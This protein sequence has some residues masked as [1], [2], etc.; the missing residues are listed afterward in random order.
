MTSSYARRIC[1]AAG[2]ASYAQTAARV[3]LVVAGRRNSLCAA[4]LRAAA[5]AASARAAAACSIRRVAPQ[6]Y[7]QQPYVPQAYP[8]QTY[9]PAYAQQPPSS[10]NGAAAIAAA[11]PP[12]GGPYVAAP[13]GYASAPAN[14]PQAYYAR[15]RRQAARRGVRP[16]RH[17]QQLHWSMPAAISIC[18]WSAACRRAATARSNSSQM[19]AERLKQGYV[20]EPHVSVEVEAYRPFF[21][22]G[23][24]TNPGQY[25]Y[26]A[27]MT[28]E[29]AVAIAGGFAPRA[30]QEQG[31]IDPQRAR[32]ADARRRAA[33]LPAAPRRHHCGQGA[34]VLAALALRRR[35]Y[36]IFLPRNSCVR[37]QARSAASLL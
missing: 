17:H 12:Q 20:R 32:P 23:E 6:V 4:E 10:R 2:H 27:N 37:L 26:V 35:H 5:G 18:R 21:I 3:L 33:R 34:V 22:L 11:N 1:A 7:A 25:P 16:G 13:Y 8:P 30:H 9:A 28:A 29:T 19:I 36:F 24:V 14:V 31:R 15:Q